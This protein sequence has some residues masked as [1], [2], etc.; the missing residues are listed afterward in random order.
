MQAATQVQEQTL[1]LLPKIA[2]VGLTVAIFGAA[3]MHLLAALFDRAAGRDSESERRMVSG[4]ARSGAMRR[5]SSSALPVFHIQA[6]P[7]RLRGGF[8]LALAMLI[9]PSLRAARTSLP[10]ACPSSPRSRSSFC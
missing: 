8:A 10:R 5:V 4:T 7:R 1:T 3:G 2:P 6:F 9:A